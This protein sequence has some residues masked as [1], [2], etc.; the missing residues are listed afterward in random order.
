MF[1]IFLLIKIY[2]I[3]PD[4][5]FLEISRDHIKIKKHISINPNGNMY[6]EKRKNPAI[7]GNQAL[8]QSTIPRPK[9]QN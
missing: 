6:N 2:K 4:D 7:K 5:L 3:K 8:I 1:D 9:L